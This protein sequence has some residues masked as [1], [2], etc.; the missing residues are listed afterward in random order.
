MTRD[1]ALL[2]LMAGVVFMA[3]ASRSLHSGNAGVHGGGAILFG[4][5][6]AL[7]LIGS[8]VTFAVLVFASL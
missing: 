3:L 4:A 6:G 7:C 8:F 5:A 2:L 1:I